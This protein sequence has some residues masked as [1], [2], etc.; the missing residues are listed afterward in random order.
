[1]YIKMSNNNIGEKN[2]E[3]PIVIPKKRGRK[4]KKDILEQELKTQL[5]NNS[6]QNINVII[7]EINVTNECQNYDMNELIT[8][9]NIISNDVNAYTN[10]SETNISETDKDINNIND[11]IELN[12]EK[13]ATKKRGRKPKGGKIIQQVVP[14]N[15]NKQTRP[16]VILHLKCSLKDLFKNNRDFNRNK[17]NRLE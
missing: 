5:E 17:K 2:N 14:T 1:M 11:N 4:S 8:S 15:I 16:N 6:A 13:P 3:K 9:T 12:E 7:E 10:I